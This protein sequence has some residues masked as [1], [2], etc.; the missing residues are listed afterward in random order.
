MIRVTEGIC[1]HH[2]HLPRSKC[3]M[4][5]LPNHH[6]LPYLLTHPPLP[7][8]RLK[9]KSEGVFCHAHPSSLVL[10][11]GEL[12]LPTTAPPSLET[13]VRGCFLP[14][15]P[16]LSRFEQGRADSVHHCPSLARRR[17]FSATPTPSLVFRARESSSCPPLPLPCSKRKSKGISCHTHLLSHVSSE[18][19]LILP[20][21]A[22]LSPRTQV[23]CQAPPLL[24]ILSTPPSLHPEN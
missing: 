10:S 24:C 7:L 22:Y 16:F 23:S 2:H 18:R 3:K 20:T 4:E 5:A 15:P 11:E 21:I 9:H 17:V 6:H 1:I 14:H 8:P 19:E 12:V 13:Q